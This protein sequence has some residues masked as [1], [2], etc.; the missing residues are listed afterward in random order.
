MSVTKEQVVNANRRD[1]FHLG[2]CTRTFGPRGGKTDDV[3]KVRVNGV[4]K[5]WQ[6]QPE[7]F[8]LPV[9][10]GMYRYGRITNENAHA[11]HA[12]GSCPLTAI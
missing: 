4:A 10:H 3:Y 1:E 12:A 6:K 11:W 5:T 2:E 9:V 8:V 7:L